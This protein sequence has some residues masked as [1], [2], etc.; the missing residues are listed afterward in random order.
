MFTVHFAMFIPSQANLIEVLK[1]ANPTNVAEKG[2]PELVA[3]E[4]LQSHAKPLSGVEVT[5][6]TITS[7]AL[8]TILQMSWLTLPTK[9][10]DFWMAVC[11]RIIKR[12]NGA[13]INPFLRQPEA[14]YT[15]K[16][17]YKWFVVDGESDILGSNKVF[18]VQDKAACSESKHEEPHIQRWCFA[19]MTPNE[20]ILPRLR[21]NCSAPLEGIFP[22]SERL[23][24]RNDQPECFD[25]F[26]RCA[27]AG[28]AKESLLAYC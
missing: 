5:Q 22:D 3:V 26:P 7:M 14:T 18:G 15:V 9:N 6:R 8:L 20:N 23:A 10:C 12:F 4:D 1:I 27:M 2:C 21:R 28:V 24:A 11:V 16:F 25:K 13:S 19:N 17:G